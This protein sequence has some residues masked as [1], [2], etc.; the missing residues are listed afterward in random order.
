MV[1]EKLVEVIPY[2]GF[3]VVCKNALRTYI[4]LNGRSHEIIFR[5]AQDYFSANTNTPIKAGSFI[6]DTEY[7]SASYVKSCVF[8]YRN[9]YIC[10]QLNGTVKLVST[11]VSSVALT[12]ANPVLGIANMAMMGISASFQQAKY[13]REK[14]WFDYEIDQYNQRRGLSALSNR[15]RSG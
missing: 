4:D 5:V 14:A 8:L 10:A 9:D 1:R 11:M 7:L 12:I 15:T 13:N 6:P 3:F 2:I